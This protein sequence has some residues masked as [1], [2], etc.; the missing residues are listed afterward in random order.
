MTLFEAFA[1]DG[2]SME[3]SLLDGDRVV[4]ARF[5]GASAVDRLGS[6]EDVELHLNVD[7]TTIDRKVAEC[8][9][10][11]AAFEHADDFDII[12]N[13]FDFLPLTYSGL[14][15]TPVITTIHGFSS[16]DILPVYERYDTTTH[17][18]AISDADRHPHLHYTATIHHGIDTAAFAVDPTPG[19]HLLYFGRI[20]P[21]KGPSHAIDVAREERTVAVRQINDIPIGNGVALE[22]RVQDAS[23]AIQVVR[24]LIFPDGHIT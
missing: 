16:P 8:L 6:V 24:I 11:A 13:S 3:P 21:D 1:I 18:V 17:Y 20:H 23:Q 12:H 9:H 5:R 10:I 15:A 14:V 2:P 7:D 19:D 4:E 22:R